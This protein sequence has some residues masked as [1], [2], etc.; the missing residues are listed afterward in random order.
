MENNFFISE[1]AKTS[2]FRWDF[3]K[4][5]KSEEEWNY[6]A[7]SYDDF[8]LF[9]ENE[10][11][12]SLPQIIPKKIHQIWIGKKKLPRQYSL[13]MKTWKKFNP[14]W[15]YI[16]W[17]DEMIN[18]FNLAN[19]EAYNACN[20]PGFKSDIARY[21]ILNKFGGLYVDTDFECLKKIPDYFLKYDFVSSI[22]FAN[23][24]TLNN[25]IIFAKADSNI[26]K[27]MINSIKVPRNSDPN[28]IMNASGPFAL[29]KNY[30]N[31]SKEEK[32]NTIILPSNIFYPYPNFLLNSKI[33]KEEFITE[34]SIAI[35]HWGMSWIKKKKFLKIYKLIINLTKKFIYLFKQRI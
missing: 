18:K 5:F 30:F 27:K 21:E 14:E 28:E 25:A 3:L 4:N 13:W 6:L 10:H 23:S 8:L 7:N 19:R 2:L 11:S 26:L 22:V 32:K 20:N 17:N 12:Q 29:S 31:L 9:R 16:F 15:E 35:H 33:K 1:F 24:P 34:E